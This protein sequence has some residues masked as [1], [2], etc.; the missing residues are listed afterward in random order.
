MPKNIGKPV[1]TNNPLARAA[2]R[3]ANKASRKMDSSLNFE[4]YLSMMVAQLKNQDMYNNT[5]T[6]QMTQ[7]M[8]SYSMVTAA[9]EIMQSHT[10][11]YAA[12]LIGQNVTAS[13]TDKTGKKV[14][15]TGTITGMSFYENTPLVYV[16]GEPYNI[17]EIT[18]IGKTHA[19][20]AAK[21]VKNSDT[22]PKAE[23]STDNTIEK[24]NS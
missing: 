21:P 11:S 14:T 1:D 17:S 10:R 13:Y 3:T 22:E 4:D 8:A 6:S 12:S 23:N 19:D 9:K 7:Q 24:K 16:N 2:A 18:V 5:D 20:K 15:N